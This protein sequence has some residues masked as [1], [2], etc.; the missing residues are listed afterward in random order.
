MRFNRRYTD[1]KGVGDLLVTMGG[2]NPATKAGEA[3][4]LGN[5]YV[6]V[7]RAMTR[8]TVSKSLL[9]LAKNTVLVK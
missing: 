8:R 3:R 5:Y 2:R 6:D 1:A 4:D 9:A 7:T